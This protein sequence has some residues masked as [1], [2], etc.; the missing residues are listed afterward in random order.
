M[1][2]YVFSA[3][4]ALALACSSSDRR[5][6][7]ARGAMA[8]STRKADSARNANFVPLS[9]LADSI[10]QTLVFPPK[11]ERWYTGA[12]RG[13]RLLVDIGR[14]DANLRIPK[15]RDIDSV[16]F[17]AYLQALDRY[18]PIRK[19]ARFRL[20][21]QWGEDDATV[22]GYDVWNGRIVATL[23]APRRVDSLA[24][25]KDPLPI[26]AELT[27]AP[28]ASVTSTCRRD[29]IPKILLARSDSVR[30]SL[31]NVV[32]ADTVRT[33]DRLKVVAKVRNSRIVGCFSGGRMVLITSLRSPNY[34]FVS[35]RAV[36]LD[37]LG[38]ARRLI[39]SDFRFRAHDGIYAFDADGDGTEDVAARGMTE[40]NG[41]TSI[42]RLV[43]GKKL[44]RLTSGFAWE[45]R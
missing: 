6:D 28:R 27:E 30:D 24:A 40:G 29:S 19:G 16:R 11:G 4:L 33:Y 22:K 18:A 10:A 43:E 44:E 37:T 15:T 32:W 45:G 35:E 36:L 23:D 5:T 21:G 17:T 1:R 12:A 2:F 20:R 42:L 3:T 25:I 39:V 8:D 31:Q 7:S 38:N 26:S 41:G 14:V 9:R 13:K 34:E